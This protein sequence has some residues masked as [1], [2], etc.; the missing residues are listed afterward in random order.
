[1]EF[2]EANP[3]RVRAE[4]DRPVLVSFSGIDG[5]GKTTQIENLTNWLNQ[6]GIKVH[7]VRFWDDVALLRELRE[8]IGHKLFKGDKGTGT[9]ESPVARRDKNVSKWYMATLRLFLCGLDAVGLKIV[10]ARLRLQRT[11]DVVIFDRYLYDQIANLNLETRRARFMVRA[12]LRLIPRPAVPCLLDADPVLARSRKPEYPIEFLQ[13]NRES[14]LRLAEMAGIKV[15]P[16]GSAEDVTGSVRRTV[17]SEMSRAQ[18]RSI[19]ILPV[20]KP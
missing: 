14:Y 7:I 11:A 5:A 9:P 15:I 8:W 6:A 2:E 12:V 3:D 18:A 17:L 1:M 10:I 20:S 4:W 19:E 13:W 16:A